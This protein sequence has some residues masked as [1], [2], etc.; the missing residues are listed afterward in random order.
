MNTAN[1]EKDGLNRVAEVAVII[2]ILTVILG[3]IL[4]ARFLYVKRNRRLG[5]ETKI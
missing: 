3:G 5:G 2:I 1:L 4:V